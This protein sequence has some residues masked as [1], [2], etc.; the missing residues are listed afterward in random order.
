GLIIVCEAD[1][2]VGIVTDGDIRRAM[3]RREAEFF[4]ISAADILTPNPKRIN[5]NTR[6]IE[7]EKMMTK[8]KVNALLVVDDSDLCVGV[9]QIYDIKL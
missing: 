9:I 4:K 1:K 6:L 8:H 7:A 5:A 3:E 2:I